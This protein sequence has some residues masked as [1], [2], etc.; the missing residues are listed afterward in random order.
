MSHLHFL[1]PTNVFGLLLLCN[2]LCFSLVDR[3]TFVLRVM[4]IQL[5]RVLEKIRKKRKNDNLPPETLVGE[6]EKIPQYDK[7]MSHLHF[8]PTNVFGFLLLCN[9][10]C[11]SLVD[12]L[13]FVLRAI[14]IQLVRVF[15]S[16]KK[17]QFAPYNLSWWKRKTPQY[18]KW[19]YHLHFLPTNV[20]GLLLLCN[21][22]CFSLV[23]RLKFVLRVMQI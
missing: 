11:F 16:W 21:V 6:N 23:D 14:R 1:I 19:M 9:A 2:A 20:F 18:G 17:S 12:R 13:T 4:Q 10:L 15:H 7:W 22:L 3:L 8:L 5:V